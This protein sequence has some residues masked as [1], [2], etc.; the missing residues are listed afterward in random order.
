MSSGAEISR[1]CAQETEDGIAL[2]PCLTE[3][4][5][6]HRPVV[7]RGTFVLL[8][9]LRCVSFQERDASLDRRSGLLTI[10]TGLV[11][12][13]SVRKPG[14]CSAS[15]HGQE[16]ECR[17]RQGRPE[18]DLHS[19]TPLEGVLE[20][21]SGRLFLPTCRRARDAPLET[22]DAEPISGP[23]L[24]HLTTQILNLKIARST[25]TMRA[26]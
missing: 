8:P 4:P 11:R 22:T 23:T 6:G 15:A 14:K 19:Q 7:A 9:P 21:R 20:S 10:G 17:H 16:T 12:D 13:L 3:R 2:I 24:N 25:E 26:R 5:D 18:K 1:H